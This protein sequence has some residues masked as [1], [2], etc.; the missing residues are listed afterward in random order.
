LRRILAERT[1]MSIDEAS[2]TEP[3]PA[4]ESETN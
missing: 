2:E 3:N 4:D 1:G